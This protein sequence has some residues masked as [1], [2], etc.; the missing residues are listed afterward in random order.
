MS[1]V[2]VSSLYFLILLKHCII[3]LWIQSLLTYNQKKSIYTSLSAQVHY[4]QHG[5]GMMFVLLFFIPWPLAILFGVCDYFAHW[6][7]DFLKTTTQKRFDVAQHSKGYWFLCSIDQGL[8][9]LT[10]YII[11]LLVS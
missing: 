4:A 11:I 7:I 8:H 1:A 2:E 5:L 10:Y 3:D 9:Y 6:H